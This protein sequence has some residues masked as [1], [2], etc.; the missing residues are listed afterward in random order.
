MNWKTWLFAFSIIIII[1]YVLNPNN[2]KSEQFNLN[3]TE[4]QFGKEIEKSKFETVPDE[5]DTAWGEKDD[6][7][8]RMSLGYNQC[9]MSCCSPQKYMSHVLQIDESVAQSEYEYVPNN[10]MCSDGYHDAGCLCLTK[11]QSDLY[12]SRLGNA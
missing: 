4:S 2:F 10:L 5:I 12:S 1:L 11:E 3:I 9:S 6:K 8:L 7:Q